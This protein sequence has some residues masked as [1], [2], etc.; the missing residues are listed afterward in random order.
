MDK[1]FC[2]H[3]KIRGVFLYS[4]SLCPWL[5]LFQREAFFSFIEADKQ[6]TVFAITAAVKES[7][8]VDMY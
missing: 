2:S 6:N 4:H 3:F 1:V 7:I 5:Y 8:D